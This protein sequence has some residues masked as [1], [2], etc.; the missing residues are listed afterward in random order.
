M[1][2]HALR[3]RKYSASNI[4]FGMGG[5]L[6]QQLD[7]DTQRFAFKCAAALRGGDWVDV[8]KQPVTDSGKTSKKGHLALV[9][10]GGAY[11]TVRAPRKDD[12]LVPVFENGKVLRTY[13]LAGC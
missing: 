13:T 10:E 2:L 5:S 1:I 3:A 6:L 9:R 7:R 4:A 11:A 8:S 12:V